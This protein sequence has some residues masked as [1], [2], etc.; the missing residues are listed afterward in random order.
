MSSENVA[1]NAFH[2]AT[3]AQARISECLS[4]SKNFLVEAGAGAGKTASLIEALRFLQVSSLGSLRPGHKVACITYTNVAKAEILERI[5]ADQRFLV[6][7]IHEFFWSVIQPFQKDMRD[8]LDSEK[9]ASALQKAGLE[10]FTNQRIEYARGHRRVTD[11]V[12][13]LDHDDVPFLAAALFSRP[14]FVTRL[15]SQYPIVLIDEY[16]DTNDALARAIMAHCVVPAVGPVFGFFGDDWQQ[17]HPG[18]VGQL[19]HENLEVILKGTNFRSGA[20][21][22]KLLN[23]MRPA[24][25]Q[26]LPTTKP[27]GETLVFHTDKWEA[28]RV[29][30]PHTQDDLDADLIDVALEQ[31][32]E[33]LAKN[34]WDLTPQ[35]TKTLILTHKS[36][37]AR[38]GYPQIAELFD[39]NDDFAKLEN[40]IVRFLVEDVELALMHYQAG[41][42]GQIYEALGMNR[43][44]VHK[45]SD[46][47]RLRTALD[48]IVETAKTG[49]VAGMLEL[50]RAEPFHCPADV[51]RR[52]DELLDLDEDAER[53]PRQAELET[54]LTVAYAEIVALREYVNHHSPYE[55]EHGVKGA[56][57]ENVVVLLGGGWNW[58]N[59]PRFLAY[60]AHP[61]KVAAK[62]QSGYRRARN[63]LY[64]CA[65]RPTTN[66][67]VLFTQKLSSEAHMVLTD[68]FGAENVESLTAPIG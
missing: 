32:R 38:Q 5:D 23:A 68:W 34:G 42:T 25:P 29:P 20:P 67:A 62:H 51:I 6:A 11:A 55:T 30:G 44:Y 50:F 37:A 15:K 43:P 53:S 60:A 16:Q 35:K 26:A 54:L 41:R 31:V 57:F 33:I 28:G 7:T 52:L 61:D 66:L 2:L 9:F 48:Q 58:Y 63:L 24:L 3:Q 17:I 65:S 56:Q 13:S 40:P 36:I 12:I 64:V 49:T 22:V 21:V 10:G 47:A 59:F 27:G 19:S 46:K 1:T 4:N 45:P 8:L 14:K 39:N 18:S